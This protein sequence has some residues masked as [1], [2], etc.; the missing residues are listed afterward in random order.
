M[1]QE[2]DRTHFGYQSVT[3]EEKTRQV[4]EV[5]TSVARRYDVMNDLMSLGVHRVWKRL[6]LELAGLRPG[7]RVLD[8]A[9]GTGDMAALVAPWVGREGHVVLADRNAEM[10]GQG[11]DRLLERGFGGIGYVQADAEALPFP[12]ADFNLVLLAFGLRNI[13]R[14]ETALGEI[15]RVLKSGGRVL[16]LEFSK[17]VV[18]L[19]NRLYALYSFT[20]LPLLGRLVAK[21]EDSYRYL[22]ESIRMHPDQETLKGMMAAAGFSDCSYYN[23][24]GGIVAVHRG[25]RP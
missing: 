6:A 23:M 8:L 19:L 2:E 7:Q 10:L 20:M 25:F 9:G 5:F 15:R 24:S 14:K 21:D 16:V 17:P 1:G 13:T 12:D 4:Q 3:P 22:A 18:P 11:R